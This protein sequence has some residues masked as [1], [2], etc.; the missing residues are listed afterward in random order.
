MKKIL[1][2]ACA[3]FASSLFFDI[4]AEEDDSGGVLLER[5][6]VTPLRME[7]SSYKSTSNVTV[8]GAG[9]IESSG[10]KSVSAVLQEKAGINTYNN[11]S[12]KTS[13]VDIRGFADTSVSNVLVLIDGRKVNSIDMSGPDWLQIPIESIER[14]EVLRGAGSVLYGDNAVG[15]VINIITKKGAGKFSGRAG[16]MMG[17]YRSRQDDIEIQGKEKQISYYLYSKYYSTE[18]YRANSALFEHDFNTRLDFDAT[19]TVSMGLS[20]GLHKD[21]YGMPGGLDDQTE[22]DQYGRRGSADASDFASTKDRFVKL[23][24]DASPQLKEMDMGKFTLDY[25]YRNRD[26]YSWFYYGGWPTATKYKIDTRSFALKNVQNRN[27]MDR[28]LHL[29]SGIDYYDVKHT[30]NG[31]ENNTDDLTIY[32][33]ELG[34]YVYSEFEFVRALFLNAGARYER[35]KYRFD[36]Q[37]ATALYTTKTP[38]ETVYSGGLKYEY[39]EGSNAYFNVQESFRF[40]ATDEWYSTWTGLNTNLKQQTGI[41]YELGIKH[42]LKDKFLVTVTPYIMDIENEIY[43]NP[44]PSPGQNENY[45]KTRRSG[46][47]LGME[48][49]LR[50]FYDIP[51]LDK[52]EFFTNYAFQDAEFR[53]GAY[54]GKQIPM[55]PKNQGNA[56]LN[57]G[58]MKNYILNVTGKYVGD[59]YAINDTGNATPKVKSYI[60][61]DTKLSYKRDAMEIYG[62]MNNVFNEKYSTYVAKSTSSAKKDYYPAPERN[63]EIGAVYK[64]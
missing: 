7:Q 5:I 12:D 53:G 3:I 8:I 4:Y 63:F 22:L 64:W 45:D 10:A 58:F 60:T 25:C 50:K 20:A 62:S 1:F 30:I 40:L 51:A 28:D 6:V 29:V 2:C 59:R 46:V 14:I 24:L 48:T 44:S 35:A 54:S 49:D 16:T 17:S 55:V 36:Q 61:M 18:G 37:K 39:A 23:S 32:K 43:V 56:G 15:G 19:D 9:E 42:N 21:D 27:I 26:A 38:S 11:S 52:L 31:S 33:D 47:E 13:K 41:Q 57:A 34:F